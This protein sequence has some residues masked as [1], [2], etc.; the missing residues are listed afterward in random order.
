MRFTPVRE[1]T[2]HGLT[3]LPL[4]GLSKLGLTPRTRS[5]GSRSPWVYSLDPRG[6]MRL[7]QRISL[8]VLLSTHGALRGEAKSLNTASEK[9][10]GS[11]GT[12]PCLDTSRFHG[13]RGE[14]MARVVASIKIYP[15]DVIISVDEIKAGIVKALPKDVEVHQFVEEP[16]AY[17]LVAL[18]AHLVMPEA[19][20]QIEQVET[21]LQ[22]VEGVGQIEVQM[23]RR[24]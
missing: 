9:M 24:V 2:L 21:A 20:G 1:D 11:A 22:A 18:I 12:L 8:T 10:R 4:Q 5:D 15:Q 6:P 19:E 14:T 7:S 23:V 13:I 3:C 16:I 17:G